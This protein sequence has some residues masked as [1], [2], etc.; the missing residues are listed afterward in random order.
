LDRGHDPVRY[1][2]VD[3][4][5][6]MAL[7]ESTWRELD[8]LVDRA[9]TMGSRLSPPEVERLLQLYQRASA[10][11]SYVHTN[12]NDPAL[13]ARLSATVGS[14]SAVI[15]STP[16]RAGRAIGRFFISTF[17]SAV[18]HA[19]RF[20]VIS[21]LLMFLPALAVGAWL[22]N[23]DHAR[24]VAISP[25]LQQAYLEEDFENYYSS[26][27]AAA[28]STKVLV[29]NIRVSFLAFVGGIVF[30]V[31]TAYLLIFNG[32]NVGVAAGLFHSAGKWPKFYGLI[33]PHGLLELSAI[34][35]AGAAGLSLGWALIAPGEHTRAR[36]LANEGR[37][38]V[39]ILIGLILAFIIAGIIEG[40]VTP[41]GLPTAM[42]VGIG[43][44]VGITF[45]SY[46]VVFGRIGVAGG[47]T[48][49]FGD[50][51]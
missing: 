41:S 26:E 13:S 49:A 36:A 33:L 20:V 29:N 4:D 14:A 40:F 12:F 8:A 7:N 5:R 3:I 21:A 2:R 30:C 46:I 34:V 6:Y 39:T 45:W 23:S 28:F 51:R 22:S 9:G 27:A 44:L 37:R 31:P 50:D 25:E 35:V 42:R 19:R 16:A 18:W 48:G 43:A 11:L 47:H 32:A 38:A 15:Y 17:P 1:K 10:H 24:D